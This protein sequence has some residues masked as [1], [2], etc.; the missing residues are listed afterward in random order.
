MQQLEEI[1]QAS[2][3]NLP[4]GEKKN[5]LQKDSLIKCM[6]SIDPGEKLFCSGKLHLYLNIIFSN[7]IVFSAEHHGGR[8]TVS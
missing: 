8:Q 5:V 7:R 2:E 4:K 6:C 3:Q 1:N